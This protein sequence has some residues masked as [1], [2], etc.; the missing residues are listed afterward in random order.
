MMILLNKIKGFDLRNTL[1]YDERYTT[2]MARGDILD[3][4]NGKI[5]NDI[6][7]AS[8]SLNKPDI[9]CDEFVISN[10]ASWVGR[11]SSSWDFAANWEANVIP[12]E[13]RDVSI[14]RGSVFVPTGLNLIKVRN[15]S[16]ASASNEVLLNLDTLQT[17][18]IY[19]SLSKNGGTINATKST[20]SMKGVALQTIPANVFENNKVLNLE[21]A[22][23]SVSGVVLSSKLDIYRSLTFSTAGLKL[24]T[25]NFLTLK[26]TLNETAWVGDL[27]GKKIEGNGKGRFG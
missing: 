4:I 21:I 16:L 18:E 17:L 19:G 3:K 7:S 25:N 11:I 10:T 14:T 6:D 26:S 12:T 13:N 15:L 8:R 1:L 22:N 2:E 24:T 5:N 23:S 27:T 20:I 9:G